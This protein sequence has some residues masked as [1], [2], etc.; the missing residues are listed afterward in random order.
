MRYKKF[1]LLILLLFAGDIAT[2]MYGLQNG[3]TEAN[4]V[5]ADAMEEHGELPALLLFLPV[6][7]GAALFA[8]GGQWFAGYY[9]EPHRQ[10]W[11]PL[12]VL[13]ILAL[14]PVAWNLYVLA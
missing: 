5:V 11:F 1:W 8:L 14:P 13:F 12:M 2:T 4:P 9:G 3:Y 7:I 10:K 6:K